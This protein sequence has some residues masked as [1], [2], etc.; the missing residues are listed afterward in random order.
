LRERAL[1][2]AAEG[3]ERR[4]RVLLER[5]LAVAEAQGARYERAL[6]LLARGRVGVQLGW[7]G[8]EAELASVSSGWEQLG[9]DAAPPFAPLADRRRSGLTAGEDAQEPTLSLLDRFSTVID[10]GRQIVS[11][12]S[13][14]EVYEA[15][16]DAA[17]AL[18]RAQRC[19][20]LEVDE[21]C[22]ALRV[23]AGPRDGE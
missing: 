5:S 12:L 6:T 4:A 7:P 22:G 23:M 14:D 13:R 15:T 10:A 21:R 20:V 8:A 1:V 9:A 19:L 16:H 2:A 17:L 3:R 18:L 11:S